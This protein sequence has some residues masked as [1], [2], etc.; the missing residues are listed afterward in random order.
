MLRSLAILSLFA[1]AACAPTTEWERA[2]TSVVQRQSD[3][4]ACLDLANW[5]ALDESDK[6]RPIYPPYRDTQF[7]IGGEEGGGGLTSS[8]SRRGARAYELAEYCMQQR[9]YHLVPIAKQ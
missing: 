8:Y 6:S 4:K 7:I 2:G 1:V 3:E 5:Q 9:G